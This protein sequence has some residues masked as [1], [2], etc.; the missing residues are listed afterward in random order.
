MISVIFAFVLIGGLGDS[1]VSE[2]P[3][4]AQLVVERKIRFYKEASIEEPFYF[5]LSNPTMI[6]TEKFTSE[7][8][9][10][11]YSTD[12]RWHFPVIQ[13]ETVVEVWCVS[14]TG[15]EYSTC[16]KVKSHDMQRA[17][18][19]LR[20]NLKPRYDLAELFIRGCGHFWVVHQDLVA[21]A[22]IPIDNQ[23]W[24]TLTGKKMKHVDGWE[25][26]DKYNIN[27]AV[28]RIREAAERLIDLYGA[29]SPPME[30][31]K[32]GY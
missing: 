25:V 22:I 15:M 21:K 11:S 13:D 2:I 5:F 30:P 23:S 24:V 4:D 6:L 3:R 19:K 20:R 26:G 14:R 31:E 7:N 18:L 10:S 29:A 9:I 16:G 32:D 17:F 8:P 12:T 28:R 1:H 27:V